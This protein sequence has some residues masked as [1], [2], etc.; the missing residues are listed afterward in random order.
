MNYAANIYAAYIA[1]VSRHHPSAGRLSRASARRQSRLF[2]LA[3]RVDP[4]A[5]P[6]SV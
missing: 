5:R 3:R 2:R 1:E 4:S 6:Y